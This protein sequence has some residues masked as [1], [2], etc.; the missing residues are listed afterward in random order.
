[1]SKLYKRKLSLVVAN[2]ATGLELGEL[3]VLFSIGQSDTSTPNNARIRIYNLKDETSKAIQKEFTRVVLQAGYEDGPYGV[4]FDGTI[5]QVRRGRENQTDKYL[6]ILAAD[7]DIPYNF[8]TVNAALAAGATQQEVLETL[9]QGMGLTLGDVGDLSNAGALP[10]GKVLFGMGRTMMQ[11]FATTQKGRWSMQN[12]KLV[13]IP[14][15]SYINKEPIE[16][17]SFTGLIGLPEQ[18]EQGISARALLNPDIQ[19]GVPVFINNASIQ[20]AQFDVSYGAVN[21]FPT[22][23]LDGLYRVMVSEFVGD[24]R[25]EDWYTD[26]VCLSIDKS[27]PVDQGVKAY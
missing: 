16:L 6:D 10:R 5:K 18:T 15:T 19:I 7:S 9:A 24:S 4:I 1:M 20:R 13:F 8:G 12:G 3:H 17:T 26:M 2:N 22:I 23:S 27:A 25:G 21:Y 11:N 14:D